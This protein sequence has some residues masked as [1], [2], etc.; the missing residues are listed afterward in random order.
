MISR[1]GFASGTVALA[2]AAT[3]RAEPF[4]GQRSG[5]V[6]RAGGTISY[7]LMGDR[8]GKPPLV[9][10]HKLGGWIQDWQH[11]APALAQGCQVFAF[12]LPGHGN[13]KWLGPPPYI[14]SQAESA[15]AILGA[16]DEMGIDQFDIAGTSLG[17]C[18]GVVL[19]SSYPDRVRRLAVLSSALRERRSLAEIKARIDDAQTNLYDRRGLPY[20][21][22]PEQ[23]INTFGI[24]HAQDIAVSGTRSRSVAGRWIQPSERGVANFDYPSAMRRINAPTLLVYGEHDKAYLK[25]RSQVEAALTNSRTEIIGNSGAF[26][27]EDNPTAVVPVLKRFFDQT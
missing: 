10:L 22:V 21:V 17:G 12:D 24:V 19:A 18:I 27:I 23:L 9:L 4:Q 7:K 20:P 6:R 13:S 8:D 16:L 25:F 5:A 26:V 3:I 2:L 14:Q 15:A 11:V 1:R